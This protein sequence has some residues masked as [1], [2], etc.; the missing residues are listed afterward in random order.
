MVYTRK[1]NIHNNLTELKKIDYIYQAE[2]LRVLINVWFDQNLKLAT[3]ILPQLDLCLL[4]EHTN[5]GKSYKLTIPQ[6]QG[7][8]IQG[9]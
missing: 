5:R 8:F 2:R 9:L 3:L 1:A 7:C 4:V 6:K